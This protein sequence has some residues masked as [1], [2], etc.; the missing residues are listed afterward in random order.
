M[1]IIYINIHICIYEYM[2]L[3]FNSHPQQ[4]FST[5]TNKRFGERIILSLMLFRIAGL[6]IIKSQL[7]YSQFYYWF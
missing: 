6:G 2:Q 5:W 7:T 4:L 1:L 3:K